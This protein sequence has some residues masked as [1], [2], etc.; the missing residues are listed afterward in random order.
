[1]NIVEEWERERDLELKA[2]YFFSELMQD[3]NEIADVIL[4]GG[5]AP[6]WLIKLLQFAESFESDEKFH[7]TARPV[8]TNDAFKALFAAKELR[9]CVTKVLSERALRMAERT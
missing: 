1:M 4:S 6:I 5:L 9:N 7:E 2:E 8:G 3:E